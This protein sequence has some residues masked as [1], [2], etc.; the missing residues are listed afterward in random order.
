MVHTHLMYDTLR[1]VCA[2]STLIIRVIAERYVMEK[3]LEV[4]GFRSNLA[5]LQEEALTLLAMIAAVIGYIWLW[6]DIWP[7]T[8]NAAPLSAGWRRDPTAQYDHH[9]PAQE[10]AV[11]FLGAPAGVE[12]RYHDG[13]C[14]AHVPQLGTDLSVY[15]ASDICQCSAS[16]AHGIPRRLRDQLIIPILNARLTP[17]APTSDVL[18]PI[19]VIAL[20]TVA[21]WLSARNLHITVAWFGQAYDNVYRSEQIARE[22]EAELRRLLK[23]LDDLSYRLERANYTLTL[24]RN[25]AEEARHLKQ[26]FAQTI[27]HELRTPLNIISAFTELMAQSPEYYG[28]PLPASYMRDLSI[29]HRNTHHLQ[30]LVNDV[31]DL[32]ASK[33]RK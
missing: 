13:V 1:W 24:E 26:E 31:L 12:Y 4:Q 27:S 28:A 18:V 25:H 19:A 15:P 10:Q 17:E 33:P 9:L 2:L 14:G 8:G 29:V 11:T 32:A 7:V 21:S 5:Y 22:H 6:I 3:P 20:T 30:T 16:A 23:A